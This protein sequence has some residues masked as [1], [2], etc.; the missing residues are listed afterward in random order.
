VDVAPNPAAR[1]ALPLLRRG[2]F[3]S[4][5]SGLVL[6][7]LLLGNPGLRNA[8]TWSAVGVLIT[9]GLLPVFTVRPRPL[10][11]T[12]SA[13]ALGSLVAY[14]VVVT[15]TQ[16]EAIA[17]SAPAPAPYSQPPAAV[18]PPKSPPPP[19][20]PTLGISTATIADLDAFIRTTK[21]H[22]Q[23]FDVFESWSQNRPL[24]R[25]VAD[26]VLA[27]GA[28]LSITWQPWVPLQGAYQRKYSLASIADGAHDAYIDMFAKS[29]K[30]FGHPVTIRLMHEMNGNWYPWGLDVNGNRRGDFVRAWRHVHDRF[31]ALAVTNVAWMWAP[32]AVYSGSAPLGPLYPG[33]AYVDEVGLSNYN[34]GNY[35]HDGTDTRWSSFGQLFDASIRQV[36]LLTHRPLWIAETAS[37]DKGGSKADWV[38]NTLASV[39]GRPDIA[40]LMW[41]DQV[42]RGTGVD[43]RIENQPAVAAAWREGYLAR[44]V[45]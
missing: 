23:A 5:L 11:T 3:L 40:G 33:D 28:R 24:D 31:A 12:Y 30:A 42:D 35:S 25:Y 45:A 22:P 6:A 18:A 38:T 20:R 37:S 44:P 16:R 9:L 13:M 14:L 41:F 10:L 7:G 8:W 1:P 34:W 43:W 32:N 36:R 19:Q 2:G 26:S 29:V 39:S 17:A 21:T 27:R 15:P 4:L